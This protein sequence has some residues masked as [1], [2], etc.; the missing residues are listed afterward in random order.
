[1]SAGAVVAV[2]AAIVGVGWSVLVG[3]G[4]AV[5]TVTCAPGVGVELSSRD[6]KQPVRKK[7]MTTNMPINL[8]IVTL[9]IPF[10]LLL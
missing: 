8:F 5:S 4:P 2:A 10:L 6:D 9:T 1:V 3:D 7:A